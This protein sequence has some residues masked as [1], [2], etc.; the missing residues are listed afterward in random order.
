[1]E[2][3]EDFSR[4]FGIC[5]VHDVVQFAV[6]RRVNATRERKSHNSVKRARMGE[7]KRKE[8]IRQLAISW[9]AKES[10]WWWIVIKGDVVGTK[11]SIAQNMQVS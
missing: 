11:I 5:V 4:R 9:E 3:L 10:R 8:P 2:E 1:L 7:G 6:C